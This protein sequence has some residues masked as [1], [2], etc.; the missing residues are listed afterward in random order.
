MVL[1]ERQDPQRPALLAH[2]APPPRHVPRRLQEHR[3]DPVR[4]PVQEFPARPPGRG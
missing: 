2:Q 1:R 4:R 3:K